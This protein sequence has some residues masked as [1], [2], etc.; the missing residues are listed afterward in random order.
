[1]KK[2]IFIVLIAASSLWA[3]SD[4][5][6]SGS[7]AQTIRQMQV[8]LDS[9]E[10]E[11]HKLKIEKFDNS[12]SATGEIRNWGKGFYLGMHLDA[13]ISDCELGYAF[14]LKHCRI[15]AGAGLLFCDVFGEHLGLT[16][17]PTSIYGSFRLGTPVFINFISLSGFCNASWLIKNDNDNL[18]H[19][20]HLASLGYGF[21]LGGDIEF[22]LSKQ[23]NLL[24]G[25]ECSLIVV[26]D[27]REGVFFISGYRL[28]LRRYF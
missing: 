24:F 5:S 13:S 7:T 22:W 16:K 18:S 19:G 15:G 14:K 8:R 3:F 17:F 27:K 4:T 23:W 10:T 1:M 6:D 20:L 28:G 26:A 25:P 21:G 9:L 11:F 2:L 12:S